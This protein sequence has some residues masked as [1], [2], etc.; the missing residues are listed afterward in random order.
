MK[1]LIS[2]AIM[3]Q[4]IMLD[5]VCAA[6]NQTYTI[7]F[8]GNSYQRSPTTRS[9][10]FRNDSIGVL[11]LKLQASGEGGVE[12]STLGKTFTVKHQG[13]D[14]DTIYIGAIKTTKPGYIRVD[15]SS[16]GPSLNLVALEVNGAAS[17]STLSYVHD[18]S[19]Y[20]GSRG[21]SVHLGYTM[22]SQPVE[23]VYSEVTVPVG[24]D[25][26]GSYYMA[27]GFGEG[28]FGMQCNSPTER[29]VLFSV[30]S[31]F[32]TD[33]P[34]TIPQDQQIK[35]LRR[36]ADV[37][38]GE[39]GNEGS[40]GQSYLVFPWQAGH[41]YRFLTSITP[42]GHGATAYTA[43]FYAPESGQ[44]RLI[45]SF[46][47]PKTDKHY[48]RA[49]SFLENFIPG[50]GYL[51]RCVQF[52]NQWARSI[53]GVWSEMLQATFTYDATAAAGVRKDY[54]GGVQNEAFF[55]KNCG[56]FDQNTKYKTT[57]ERRATKKAPQIDFDALKKL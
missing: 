42:D 41:T 51:T 48:T 52:G 16:P 10:Y 30:W 26:E 50:Q 27:N 32:T 14:L 53:D 6:S 34:K 45:A 29:R 46:L 39:F 13:A 3:M 23:W 12:I 24:Q 1:R 7:G 57:F 9:L 8:P 25:I 44:W 5:L 20:W 37:H 35:L 49:H 55:L 17:Q 19:T 47:R 4:I 36:G 18:F 43:Y 38:I 21:P 28:Y 33:D 11:E 22:P 56:F 40:G 2:F 15:F 54:A 31:P